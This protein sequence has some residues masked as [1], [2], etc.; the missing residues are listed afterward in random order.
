MRHHFDNE[1]SVCVG[2][3]VATCFDSAVDVTVGVDATGDV[4]VAAVVV[5]AHGVVVGRVDGDSNVGSSGRSSSSSSSSSCCCCCCCCCCCV[6]VDGVLVL[7][8]LLFWCH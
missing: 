2:R 7:L 3:V 6:A 8:L 1:V 5:A 4:D